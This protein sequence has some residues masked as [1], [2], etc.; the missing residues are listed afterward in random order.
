MMAVFSLLPGGYPINQLN[1]HHR[2]DGLV[3]PF[4]WNANITVM[5]VPSIRWCCA[6]LVHT[7]RHTHRHR[8]RLQVELANLD[9]LLTF[10]SEWIVVYRLLWMHTWEGRQVECRLTGMRKWRGGIHLTSFV[11]SSYSYIL[12]YVDSQVCGDFSVFLVNSSNLR[13]QTFRGKLSVYFLKPQYY[14]VN[15]KTLL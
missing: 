15:C 6:C 8:C 2:G 9:M 3:A 11:S 4:S 12:I 7:H 5:G 14:N 1:F 10:I 13:I